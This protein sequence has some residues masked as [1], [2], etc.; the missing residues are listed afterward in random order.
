MEITGNK[1]CNGAELCRH[2]FFCFLSEEK[3]PSVLQEGDVSSLS[4]PSGLSE[5]GE[6]GV[7]DGTLG[8][9]FFTHVF[10]PA[11]LA[12]VQTPSHN[13]LLRHCSPDQ[14][15][16]VDRLMESNH[17]HKHRK[18][19]HHPISFYLQSTN[20]IQSCY[21]LSLCRMCVLFRRG[22]SVCCKTAQNA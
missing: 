13:S 11:P 19:C 14:F 22:A 2:L 18:S 9:L 4:W 10:T 1:K 12:H 8:R 21:F 5:T 16:H 17:R 15:T 20:Q 7:M 6:H 3:R